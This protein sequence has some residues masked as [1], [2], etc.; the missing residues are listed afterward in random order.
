MTELPPP[1]YNDIIELPE[2]TVGVCS[3]P[4]RETQNPP[5]YNDV[6]NT[7]LPTYNDVNDVIIYQPQPQPQPQPQSQ[8]QPDLKCYK[9]CLLCFYN[10]LEPSCCHCYY[11]FGFCQ[12]FFSNYNKTTN[13]PGDPCIWYDQE[14]CYPV[15]TQ[16]QFCSDVCCP[17]RCLI[18]LPCLGATFVKCQWNIVGDLIHCTKGIDYCCY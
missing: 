11:L 3:N 7:Q 15:S 14:V 17:L 5:S 16:Q 8:P 4:I 6:Y 12:C 13:C 9:K 2:Y 1:N 10:P 18:C